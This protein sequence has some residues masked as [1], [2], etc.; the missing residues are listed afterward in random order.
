M[1]P[2]PKSELVLNNDG[3]IY[4][5]KLH[6]EQ[7]ADTIL[8]VG[9]QGRVQQ[10]SKHFDRIEYKVE[11]REF[12]THTGNIGNKRI[13][14]LSTGIGTDNIDIVINELDALVNFDLENRIEK[15]EKKVLNIIR[16]GT[17]GAV[18]QDIPVDCYIA[19]THGMGMDNLM[20]YYA[21]NSFDT[22]M[23]EAFKN[24]ANW[25]KDLSLPYFYKGSKILLK[26]FSDLRSGITATSPGF[27]GPQGRNIR[28]PFSISNLHEQ[29]NT[30]EYDNL[31]IT[32][33]EM[34]TAALYGLGKLLGHQCLTICAILA[35]RIKQQYS[36]DH[37]KT[38]SEM[39]P[40]VL[41]RLTH[42]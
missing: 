22:E 24:H 4:H 15:R 32:N 23:G 28:L 39:I 35:N 38:V 31:K 13:T 37:K 8:V 20:Y 7:I 30:F 33:F 16:L 6:S 41:E 17:S 9:D 12:V 27:Y 34:E 42:E 26:K 11:N 36:K 19:S 25:P 5:L 18:Q 3:S 10:I 2:K 14:A 1:K 21:N 29:L 40:F